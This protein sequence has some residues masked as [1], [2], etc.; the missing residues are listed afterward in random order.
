MDENGA[1]GCDGADLAM[2]GIEDGGLA[3]ACSTPPTCDDDGWTYLRDVAIVSEHT[4]SIAMGSGPPTWR[5]HVLPMVDGARVPGTT[6]PTGHR[7][8]AGSVRR[9]R[10]RRCGSP[11][12][13][14]RPRCSPGGPRTGDVSGGRPAQDG[15]PL[16]RTTAFRF[17]DAVPTGRPCPTV[18]DASIRRRH[19]LLDGR[20][21]EVRVAAVNAA[22]RGAWSPAVVGVSR[23]PT[24]RTSPVVA[25]TPLPTAFVDW[26]ASLDT[27]AMTSS[28][29]SCSGRLDGQSWTEVRDGRS[30]RTDAVV[31]DLRPGREVMIRGAAVNAAGA[32]V[33]SKAAVVTPRR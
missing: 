5:R 31:P 12:G 15:G 1:T 14:A 22:G 17:A 27:A 29:T 33:V 4:N 23:Q 25:A 2:V 28:I 11:V 3:A 26:R 21:F 30:A 8:R 19:G 7:T 10:R 13:R 18:V 9:S 16:C 20:E 32:R 6:T 24:E